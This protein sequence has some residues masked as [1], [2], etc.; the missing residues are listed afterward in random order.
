MLVSLSVVITG[1]IQNI[2]TFRNKLHDVKWHT[3]V[4]EITGTVLLGDGRWGGASGGR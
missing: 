1:D 3:A 4:I 2:N